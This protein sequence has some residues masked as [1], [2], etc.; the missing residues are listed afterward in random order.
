MGTDGRRYDIQRWELMTGD[1]IYRY[2][3][4]WQEIRYTEMETDGRRYD[5]QNWDVM[6]GDTIYTDGN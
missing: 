3:N 6:A 2:G 4:S 1:T 5:T